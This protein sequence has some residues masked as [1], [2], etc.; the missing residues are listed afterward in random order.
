MANLVSMVGRSFFFVFKQ[1]TAYEM[2]ISDW[3]SDVCSSDLVDGEFAGAQHTI[4]YRAR[5]NRNSTVPIETFGVVAQWSESN[6]L[7]DVWASLQMPK[8]PDQLAA[9]LR[10]PGHAVRVHFDEIGRASCR[11][12]GL[13]YVL[14]PEVAVSIQ[15][16]T[17]R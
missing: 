4:T 15:K 16:Q 13:Q 7:L 8:Y 2:R 12:R 10:L 9:A 14:F 5:W 3:S 1:N 6:Q 11:E 17:K